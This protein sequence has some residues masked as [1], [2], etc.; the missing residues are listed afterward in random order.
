LTGKKAADDFLERMMRQIRKAIAKAEMKEVFGAIVEMDETYVGGK[1]RKA[2][3]HTEKDKKNNDNKR[4]KGTSKILVIG[5]KE[6]SMGKVHAVVVTK[7]K[8][9]KQLTRKQ[10]FKVLNTVCKDNP[11]VMTDRFSGYNILEKENEKNF[12][13]IAS[14]SFGDV[15]FGERNPH[16][17]Y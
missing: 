1:P 17:W 4:G 10:L 8:D 2:N 3:N 6:R 13:R 9:G 12:I 15:F 11:T 5:V 16:Q 7:N 14:R